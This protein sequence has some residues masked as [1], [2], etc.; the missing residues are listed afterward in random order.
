L[1][2]KKL[3]STLLYPLIFI[4]TGDNLGCASGNNVG[5][6]YVYKKYEHDYAWLLNNDVVIDEDTLIEMVKL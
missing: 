3:N 4:Q 2:N 6:R 1:Y 5:L